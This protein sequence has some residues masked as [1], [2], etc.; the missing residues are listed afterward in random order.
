VIEREVKAMGSDNW[1]LVRILPY[2]DKPEKISGAVM[3]FFDITM[4]K[5]VQRLQGILD[6]LPEHIAVL[7]SDGLITQV[8]KA[9]REFAEQSDNRSLARSGPG[10]NY[11]EVCHIQ[12]HDA[13]A[14][15]GPAVTTGIREVL[16]KQRPTF[17]I[18]YPCHLP[19]ERRWFLMH[20]APVHHLAGGV[21]VSHINMTHWMEDKPKGLGQ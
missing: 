11:L 13:N 2:L 6:S 8:N 3:T 15:L 17:S 14:D 16:N 12:E 10:I 20:A 19:T 18:S 9:W 1:Y 7:D 5:D 4:L 21:V